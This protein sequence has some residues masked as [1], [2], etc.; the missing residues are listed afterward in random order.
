MKVSYTKKN[1]KFFLLMLA[2]AIASCVIT[3]ASY[4]SG[5][6]S[7]AASALGVVVTPVQKLMDNIH[8][9]TKEKAEYFQDID[10]LLKE[11]AKLKSTIID[12]NRKVSELTPAQKEN[13]MLYNFLELKKERNDIKFVNADIISRS[14][15][16]YTSDIT[17]DKGSVH[18]I[19]KDMA[20][21][22]E[23]NSLLGV[24]VEVGATYSRG[25]VL[26]SYDFSVG[27]ENERSG[28]PGIMSGNF[29]LSRKG[30][31]HVADLA[32]TADYKTGDII[33]T[34]GL[35]DMYPA[36]IYVGTVTE[37]VPN[38]LDYTLNATIKPAASVF[39]TDMV[40][41]ITDFDRTYDLTHYDASTAE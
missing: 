19:K 23:D 25:K 32:D 39:S 37:I 28:Q 9:F 20:I 6:S 33:K 15:S 2:I 34:S 11:N 14:S 13:E 12:L 10:N 31:C 22:T 18:G 8:R 26:T 5:V 4:S 40:M 35:G 38:K 24:I 27:I 16:N 30:L 36:G 1:N 29:E 7:I 41:I 3:G 21:V 17:L